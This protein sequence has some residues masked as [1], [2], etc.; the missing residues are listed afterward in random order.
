MDADLIA[1]GKA[2]QQY[3]AGDY[4]ECIDVFL[5]LSS[6]GNAKSTFYAGVIYTKGNDGVERDEVKARSMFGLAI[7]QSER[8]LPGAVLS[9]ALMQYQGKGGPVDYVSALKNYQTV[10]GN[11]FAQVMIGMMTLLGRGCENNEDAALQWFDRAWS[12]GHPWGL[13][14]AARIRF[15]R[16]S[17]FRGALDW[18]R[19]AAMSIWFYG[20][21]RIPPTKSPAEVLPQFWQRRK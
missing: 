18:I 21:R 17:Y 9:L 16:G 3:Q 14:C 2:L 11:P 1:Y 8:F 20:I 10:K 4:G 6:A 13:G 12:N 15:R 7:S 5:R 19:G